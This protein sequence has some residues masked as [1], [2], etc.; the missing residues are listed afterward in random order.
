MNYDMGDPDM[1]KQKILVTLLIL[2]MVLPLTAPL[3]TG[4]GAQANIIPITPPG[5]SDVINKYKGQPVKYSGEILNEVVSKLSPKILDTSYLQG[6]MET[7]ISDAKDYTT[8]GLIVNIGLDDFDDGLKNLKKVIDR[9]GDKYAS[10][11]KIWPKLGMAF[12]E[13]DASN[14]EFVKRLAVAIATIGSVDYVDVNDLAYITLFDSHYL[15]QTAQVYNM[16]GVNGTG[17]TVAVLDTGIEEAHPELSGSVVA[18]ADFINGLPSP[19][20]D[21]GH[22]TFVSGVIAARGVLPWSGGNGLWHSINFDDSS[23]FNYPGVANLTYAIDVSA[24]AGSDVTLNYTQRYW[25]EDLFDYGYV[26]YW[27]DSAPAPVLLASYTGTN[28]TLHTES[29][30]ITV[31][32]GATTLYISFQ[33]EPDSSIQWGGWWLD[34]I[35]VYNASNPTDIIFMDDVEGPAPPEVI[36]SYLWSRTTNRLMGMAPGTSLV[37]AKVCDSGGSCPTT[38]ILDGIEFAINQSVDIIS[39]SLGGPVSGYDPMMTAVDIANYVYNI[40]PIIAAGN[41][42]PGYF[43]IESPA[44]AVGAIAVGAATKVNTIASFSSKGPNPFNY[45]IKPDITA[46]GRH[47][48]SITSAQAA[49]LPPGSYAIDAG[50]GTSYSTPMIS[51]LVALIKQAH[52][53]WSPEMIRSALISTATDLNDSVYTGAAMMNPYVQGGG[54]VNIWRAINTQF[55]PMP[56]KVSFGS[57]DA[58]DILTSLI[59]LVSFNPGITTATVAGLELY[60]LDGTDFTAWIVS[61]SVGDVIALNGTLNLTVAIPPN[62]ITDMLYWG[63]INVSVAGEYYQ[64]IFGFYIPQ[65]YWLNGTVYDVVTGA[66]LAG[67]NVSAV[68]PDLSIVFNSTLTDA[69]GQFSM[70][71]PSGNIRVQA[72]LPGYYQYYSTP[73]TLD[74]DMIYDVF[75]TPRTGYNPLNV[76]VVYDE[77]YGMWFLSQLYA[78]NMTPVLALNGTLGINMTLWNTTIQQIAADAILSGDFPVV[79]WFSGGIWFPFD[80]SLDAIALIIFSLFYDG[81]ILVEGGD[82]AWWWGGTTVMQYVAHAEYVRD[83]SK[84]VYQINITRSHPLTWFLPA[85]TFTIDTRSNTIGEGYPDE[86]VPAYGGFDIANWSLLGTSA[87]VAYD[88]RPVGESRTVYYA[89]PYDAILDP[90]MQAALLNYTLIWLFDRGAPV[91]TSPSVNVSINVATGTAIAYWTM[92]SDQPFNI[93][94]YNLYLNG[95][96]IASNLPATTTSFDLTPYVTPGNYYIFTVEAVDVLN[97]TTS[98]STWFYMIPPGLTGTAF[99]YVFNGTFSGTAPVGA[100][101]SFMINVTNAPVGLQILELGSLPANAWNAF[102]ASSDILYF[103]VAMVNASGASWLVINITY[104]EP[105]PPLTENIV[106]MWFDGSMWREVSHYSVDTASNTVTIWINATGTSPTLADLTGTLFRLYS[107]PAPLVGGDAVVASAGGMPL[108]VALV[109]VA[110]LLVALAS[111]RR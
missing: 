66:P 52:P 105:A 30:N 36:N 21:H 58:G 32:P 92:F 8:F 27:F 26:Y 72:S 18:W 80:D 14:P 89:F 85:T 71:V 17:V 42:G 82:I 104:P 4:I 1:Y 48:V 54:L 15:L 73:F 68:S 6:I 63:R 2:V 75:M 11:S 69:S 35:M 81:G 31:D 34:D 28:F 40:T 103:D 96:M 98:L 10:I 25:I 45:D 53:D 111:R 100:G 29:F 97:L 99:G 90:V 50:S 39:M 3:M 38:A 70:L 43:T 37:G 79:A 102:P 65:L 41:S 16:L 44:A 95:T 108:A 24:Y 49:G 78:P 47:I 46:Y 88:G 55:L 22:G 76:L 94:S 13:V 62:P 59:S 7:M 5:K 20:D 106:P 109:G 67:V 86:V 23:E 60:A 107:E 12:V 84:D 74:T 91:Y 57:V 110:L 51:G 19:Y 101:T 33:Y 87:I 64:V 77:F 56:A 83:M 61:P 93:V 9:Y